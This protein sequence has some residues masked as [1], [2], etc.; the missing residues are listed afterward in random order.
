MVGNQAESPPHANIL[1]RA[2]GARYALI[3]SAQNATP[4]TSPTGNAVPGGILVT[5]K[6]SA[7]IAFLGNSPGSFD[8]VTYLP[9]A[10]L[11][12]EEAPQSKSDGCTEVIA[13]TV[14]PL[15][16]SNLAEDCPSYG[17]PQFGSLQSTSLIELVK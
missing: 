1:V 7:S 4:L 17:T 12:F 2:R 3:H 10:N 9:N 6:S 8:G 5:A 16:T 13:S 14:S 11:K 15:G